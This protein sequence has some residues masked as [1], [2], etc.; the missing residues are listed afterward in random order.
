MSYDNKLW[1][2]N[3]VIED[4]SFS[5]QSIPTSSISLCRFRL[6]TFRF[7]YKVGIDKMESRKLSTVQ[8]YICNTNS[9]MDNFCDCELVKKI[10]VKAHFFVLYLFPYRLVS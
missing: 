9:A 1:Y 10:D 2:T 6:S 3:T 4:A 5:V 8:Y 7:I